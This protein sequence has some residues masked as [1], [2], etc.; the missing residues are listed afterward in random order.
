MR[1][2]RIQDTRGNDPQRLVRRI[3]EGGGHG[4]GAA[5]GADAA[6]VVVHRRR[7]CAARV[8]VTVSSCCRHQT[9]EFAQDQSHGTAGGAGARE[10]QAQR[11]AEHSASEAMRTHPPQTPARS[12]RRAPSLA[13]RP[14]SRSPSYVPSPRLVGP[15]SAA[16]P[17][18]PGSSPAAA[19]SPCAAAPRAR[20][21]AAGAASGAGLGYWFLGAAATSSSKHQARDRRAGARARRRPPGGPWVAGRAPRALAGHSISPW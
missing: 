6:V 2:G 5:V 18:R 17:L 1:R 3:D 19:A 16:I 10:R 15:A 8:P 14:W 9:A 12:T 13:R 11:R 7:V 4:D 21:A 20:A